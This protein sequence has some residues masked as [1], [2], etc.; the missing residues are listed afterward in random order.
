[1]IGVV[2]R[3]FEAF[4][5]LLIIRILFSWIPVSP[6]NRT[7]Y[8]FKSVIYKITEFYLRPFRNLIPP[9]GSGGAYID[10]S[11]IIGFIA[12]N[13]IR[14]IVIGILSSIGGF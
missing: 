5:W 2:N 1:M 4:Y 9:I 12:L 13:F 6:T 8:E 11:P 3:L 14:Q 10:I 7:L